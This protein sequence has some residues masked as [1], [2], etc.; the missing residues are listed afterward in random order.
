M[1][2]WFN[3]AKEFMEALVDVG[4]RH[5]S[6]PRVPKTTTVSTTQ[7]TAD[8]PKALVGGLAAT[9]IV[10][11]GL[12]A[13]GWLRP[14]EAADRAPPVRTRLALDSLG[15]GW[16]SGKSVAISWDGSMFAFFASDGAREA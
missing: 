10:M 6:L 3:T 1:V 13:W 15:I 11:T 16:E 9:L 5:T 2:E 8:A 7:P 12:A 4:F 14:T